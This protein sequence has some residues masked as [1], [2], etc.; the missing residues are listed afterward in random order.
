M[1]EVLWQGLGFDVLPE[2]IVQNHATVSHLSTL[3]NINVTRMPQDIEIDGSDPRIPRHPG[4]AHSVTYIEA[5]KTYMIRLA[6]Y[7]DW[8]RKPERKR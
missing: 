8:N 4:S 6:I 7:G 5:E 3:P 1:I 2:Q